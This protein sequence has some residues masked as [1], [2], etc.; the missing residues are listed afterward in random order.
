MSLMK[1]PYY[2]AQGYAG[3]MVREILVVLGPFFIPHKE[4]KSLGYF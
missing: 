4:L 2:P 1:P 3:D